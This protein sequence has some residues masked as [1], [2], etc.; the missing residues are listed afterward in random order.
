LNSKEK[1][2]LG[3]VITADCD[4][5]QGKAGGQFTAL[6]ILPMASYIHGTWAEE[7]LRKLIEKRSKNLCDQIN[8]EIRK[9]QPCLSSL[10]PDSLAIWLRNTSAEE[11]LLRVTGNPVS[12]DSKLLRELNGL[13]Y[14]LGTDENMSALSRLKTAWQFFGIEERRQVEIFRTALK[15]SGGFHD[16]FVLP[17]LPRQSGLGFIVMLRSIWTIKSIDIF[18]TEQDARIYNR[19][20]AFHRLGRLND[21][22]RF[23][24]T[25]KLAFLF[26]RIGMTNDF[27]SACD[28]AI[29]CT[30][31][32]FFKN[33]QC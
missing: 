16:F 12:A 23:S 28:T 11:I 24:V 14:A 18:L 19:P 17:E 29:E 10:S 5:A 25:Q 6:E 9:L 4:I 21:G 27:E 33:E 22:I 32:E 31:E 2:K 8:I 3:V 26:S 15:G 30:A 13:A 7:Q 20:D 1:F